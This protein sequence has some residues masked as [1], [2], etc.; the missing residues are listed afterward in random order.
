MK[1]HRAYSPAGAG[2]AA[3]DGK[4]LGAAYLVTDG[5][6]SYLRVN[7]RELSVEANGSACV[8]WTGHTSP[9]VALLS[10]AK[11]VLETLDLGS[12]SNAPGWPKEQP[13]PPGA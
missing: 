8:V 3:P 12:M 13:L 6:V 2:A 5:S 11:D 4:W 1:L 7:G 9:T 10:A